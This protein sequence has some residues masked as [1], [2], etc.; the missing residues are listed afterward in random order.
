MLILSRNCQV[1]LELNEE[2]VALVLLN[3]I[4]MFI[5]E[6][7]QVKHLYSVLFAFFLMKLFI[8]RFQYLNRESRIF[9]YIFTN[10]CTIMLL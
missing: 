2:L 3:I 6:F 5:A 4:I 9:I 8:L 7:N 10:L 1:A